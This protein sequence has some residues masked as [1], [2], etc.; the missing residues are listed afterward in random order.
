MNR[1]I[2]SL[3][4]H[5]V[6]LILSLICA[7]FLTGLATTGS[8]TNRIT[9]LNAP[10]PALPPVAY[11]A[12]TGGDLLCR[13][14]ARCDI[15]VYNPA[16]GS[17][18]NVTNTT[19]VSEGSPAVSPDG[20]HIAFVRGG[21]THQQI[22]VM[23]AR[24]EDPHP[25]AVDE[26]K[27][28][29]DPAW[30]SDGKK[31]AFSRG[32]GYTW[33]IWTVNAD[34][35]GP[36]SK[37]AEETN[38]RMLRPDWSPD[39]NRIVFERPVQAGVRERGEIWVAN[40]DGSG[41]TQRWAGGDGLDFRDP[42]WSPAGGEIAFEKTSGIML[43][44]ARQG[45]SMRPLTGDDPRDF[46][47]QAGWSATGDQVVF[48]RL[49]S[50]TSTQ[51]YAVNAAGGS[52]EQ[53]ITEGEDPAPWRGSA[54]P[55]GSCTPRTITF[56][57]IEAVGC[58]TQH[59]AVFEAADGTARIN[60]IDFKSSGKITL[61]ALGGSLSIPGKVTVSAGDVTLLV[62]E[63][64]N[65][66]LN[67]EVTLTL[68][69]GFKLKGFPIEGSA[70]FGWENGFAKAEIEVKLPDTLGGVS[71]KA[72][73]IANNKVGLQLDSL[74]VG[75]EKA[76]LGGRLELKNLSVTYKHEDGS[77]LWT[78]QG[79]IVLP[80]PNKVEVTADFTLKDGSFDSG[81]LRVSH[82]GQYIANGIYL[83]SISF[84]IKTDPLTLE[85]GAGLSAGPEIDGVAAAQLDGKLTYT[86]ANPHIFNVSGE[87]KLVGGEIKLANGSIEYR[88][89]GKVNLAGHLEFDKFGL[90]VNGDLAGWIDGT[91]AFNIEGQAT[92]GV[93]LFSL[94]GKAVVSTVGMAACGTAEGFG[95]Q[96]SLGVGYKWHQ[97]A[98][99]LT[100]CDL[101]PY[102]ERLLKAGE[103][104]P[105]Y[106]IPGG[107]E[108]AAFRVVGTTAPPRI[109]LVGPNGER[110]TMPEK[111]GVTPGGHLVV[112]NPATKTTYVALGRPAAGNWRIELEKGSSGIAKVHQAN[113]LPP[114][115]VN[116][117]VERVVDPMCHS[118]AC[119]D[120]FILHWNLKSIPG[121]KVT[122]AEVGDET[123]QVIGT[124]EGE[125]GSI[126]FTPG[127]GHGGRKIV[128]IVEQDGLPRT[129]ISVTS[130]D[131]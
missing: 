52:P 89:T 9:Q 16:N 55:P 97:T 46:D 20:T 28:I 103:P 108:A 63:N 82:I 122:F 102:T 59:G 4:P 131:Y 31:I 30:S 110:V 21:G 41:T 118:L 85:G 105:V 126:R 73:F 64:L 127:A 13:V 83:Q 101:G 47:Y 109:T 100:S 38:T 76:T 23:G 44:E 96:L 27:E 7:V 25:V 121:Q 48:A 107:L 113:S 91:K 81:H 22:W 34:G 66:N 125:S 15:W 86:F 43:M 104:A 69:E 50:A 11:A 39:G 1:I 62:T 10:A 129:N 56:G 53:F 2:H 33:G 74:S 61:D 6:A 72:G 8:A 40:T 119:K 75:V 26:S 78:G 115:N 88:S 14:G 123:S 54:S 60:G 117:S 3:E 128:A 68:P 70:T 130:F 51:I 90:Q 71:G 92:V 124:A 49:V 94:T 84:G 65:W 18:I 114:V 95:G 42:A 37:V 35:S 79:T 58:F 36:L 24:G 116:A 29:I 111:E 67:A 45:G 12:P 120:Q 98:D 106:T 80:T 5:R 57:Q 32:I 112:T 17:R 77:D 87:L 19:D 93:P 99:F